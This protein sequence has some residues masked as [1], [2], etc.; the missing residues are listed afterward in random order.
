MGLNKVLVSG[1]VAEEPEFIANSMYGNALEVKLDVNRKDINKV[2]RLT[3]YIY[4]D[5]LIERAL[6]EVEVGDYFVSQS[7]R[8][9]TLDF[10]REKFLVCPHCHETVRQLKRASQT[11]I[12]IFDFD[13]I[14]GISLEESVGVNRVF[15]L[16]LVRNDIRVSYRGD[17]VPNWTKFQ[18]IVNR[19]KSVENRLKDSVPEAV[20]V[21]SF[22]IPSVACFGKVAQKARDKVKKGDYLCV[23]GSMQERE[24]RQDIVL[25]CPH[26]KETSAQ[27]FEFTMREIIPA[28]ISPSRLT[29]DEIKEQMT[30]SVIMNGVGEE[31]KS[32]FQ[33]K[34]TPVDEVVANIENRIIEQK[35]NA[36]KHHAEKMAKQA[37]N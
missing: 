4:N 11:D 24:V 9:V 18:I 5:N 10:Y 13:V 14:R 6:N 37:K 16:G 15:E 29:I 27:F 30:E 7:A 8:L 28:S 25:K 1:I 26:C 2:E 32:K 22:D 3:C 31:V 35:L 17:G 19:P 12:I 21:S 33:A 34:E 36:E 20:K 23:E